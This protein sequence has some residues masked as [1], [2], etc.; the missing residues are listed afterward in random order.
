MKISTS[1]MQNNWFHGFASLCHK[2][3]KIREKL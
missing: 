1:S 3:K 2:K